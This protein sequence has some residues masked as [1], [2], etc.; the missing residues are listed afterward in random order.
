MRQ[1][2][3]GWRKAVLVLGLVL[4]PC[5]ASA[6][7]TGD[8][9]TATLTEANG[10]S[11][12]FTDPA[13]V[14]DP[15]GPEFSGIFDNLVDDRSRFDLD[16]LDNGFQLSVTCIDPLCSIFE[17]TFTL[18]LS[19][20]DFTPPANLVGL[21]NPSGDLTISGSPVITPSSIIITFKPFT[22]GSQGA[23][24]EPVVL[25]AASFLTEPRATGPTVPLPATLLLLSAGLGLG[26][27]ALR[28]PRA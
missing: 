24:E 5:V 26:A 3:M 6:G 25:Y 11:T 12:I 2:A 15:G 9:V 8:S 22:L 21:F 18:T 23:D 20:L 14:L 10:P 13:T 28:R 1:R 7:L 16:L 4:M 27:L 17:N 19:N